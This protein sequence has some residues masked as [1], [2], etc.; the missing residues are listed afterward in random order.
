MDFGKYTER[1]GGFI[2]SAQ[3]LALRS[4]HQQITP[5]HI[6]KVLLEDREGLAA[7]L[8]RAA[9]GDPAG[10]L[11]AC[12]SELARLPRV[13]GAGAGQVYLATETE[14]LLEDAGRV[15]DKAGD[16][17]VTVERLLAAL[18]L[19]AGTPAAKVLADAGVTA[20]GLN[21]AIE[22][23]RKGHAAT[24]ATAEDSYDALKKY[25]RDLTAEAAEGKIDPVIGRDEEICRAIQVLSR[26]TKNNPVLIGEPGVGKTAIVE[27]LATRMV[28]GDVPESLKDKKLM[29]LDLG[30]LVAG[31]SSAASSRSA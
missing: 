29:V 4:N 27:G 7:N 1:A 25:A 14:R 18:V 12:E 10:A 13:D 19:A 26:R 15:A 3:A 2:Q 22:D 11:K 5:L 24:S 31:P 28:K 21:R 23:V 8:A 20:Q 30:A 17:F 9:G 6:L 16:S